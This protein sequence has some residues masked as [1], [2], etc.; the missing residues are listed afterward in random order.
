M[1]IE[2]HWALSDCSEYDTLNQN[3]EQLLQ[4]HPAGH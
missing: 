4:Y 1:L 2:S 3:S